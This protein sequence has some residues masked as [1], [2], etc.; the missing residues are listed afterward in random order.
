[1]AAGQSYV[2]RFPEEAASQKATQYCCAAVVFPCNFGAAAHKKYW[3]DFRSN[4]IYLAA[5]IRIQA[6]V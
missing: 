2:N 6:N 1:M 4:T 3:V 5:R